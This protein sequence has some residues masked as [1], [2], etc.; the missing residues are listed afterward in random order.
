MNPRQEGFCGFPGQLASF[1]DKETEAQ[2]P[3]VCCMQFG[4]LLSPGS[5]ACLE[6][7]PRSERHASENFH[8]LLS[9]W[10]T[11]GSLLPLP[12][13]ASMAKH[14]SRGAGK[15]HNSR[16]KGP[17]LSSLHPPLGPGVSSVKRE[18]SKLPPGSAA[19]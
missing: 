8:K 1:T 2:R 16:E 7:A 15:R 9:A 14:R 11:P 12:L 5:P 18:D 4:R 13:L 19:P 10:G 17:D 3:I 6:P